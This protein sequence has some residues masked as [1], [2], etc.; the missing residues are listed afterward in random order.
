MI[1]HEVFLRTLRI[2]RFRREKFLRVQVELV[3]P[4][5]KKFYQVALI[6]RTSQPQLST[7]EK[8]KHGRNPIMN[9]LLK[10]SSLFPYQV[11]LTYLLLQ[12]ISMDLDFRNI[13]S[14]G[15]LKLKTI[16]TT[17]S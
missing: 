11:A 6:D 10:R 7:L 13:S 9:N 15:S 1:Y 4:F 17:A 8:T 3:V 12:L 5:S 2:A 16:R 14:P